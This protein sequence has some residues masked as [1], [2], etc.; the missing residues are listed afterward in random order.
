MKY[1]YIEH[2][3]IAT[4]TCNLVESYGLDSTST[5]VAT[6]PPLPNISLTDWAAY[7]L[8]WKW[9]LTICLRHQIPKSRRERGQN[10]STVSRESYDNMVIDWFRRWRKLDWCNALRSQSVPC[11]TFEMVNAWLPWLYSN[12]SMSMCFVYKS[13]E[14]MPCATRFIQL[15]SSQTVFIHSQFY[16]EVV[17]SDVILHFTSTRGAF[18]CLIWFQTVAASTEHCVYGRTSYFYT[19]YGVIGL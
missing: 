5:W 14:L 15:R 1:L 12:C 8:I 2:F 9:L 7:I 18:V 19:L 13:W 6:P 4:S 3:K 10:I 16:T 11:S 17:G